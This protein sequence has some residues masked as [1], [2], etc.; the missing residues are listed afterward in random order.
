VWRRRRVSPTLA[1]LAIALL[2]SP[3]FDIVTPTDFRLARP[4][5]APRALRT[6]AVAVELLPSPDTRAVLAFV[7]G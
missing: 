3:L 4:A 1:N 6:F 2:A 7:R 5:D